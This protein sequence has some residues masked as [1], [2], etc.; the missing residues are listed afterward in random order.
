MITSQSRLSTLRWNWESISLTPPTIMAQDI[1][2]QLL[3]KRFKV[4]VT[5]LSLPQSEAWFLMKRKKFTSIKMKVSL[6]PQSLIANP[7]NTA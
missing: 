1:A 2:K 4:I 6:L 7:L 5:K 3:E